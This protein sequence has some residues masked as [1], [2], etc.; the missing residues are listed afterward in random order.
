ML[1]S[2][3][4]LVCKQPL[5]PRHML[6]QLVY[7]SLQTFIEQFGRPMPIF[8]EMGDRGTVI[9]SA[10]R[11]DGPNFDERRARTKRVFELQW[12]DV[13]STWAML[14]GISESGEGEKATYL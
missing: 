4:R 8:P 13:L 2:I 1:K 12:G 6:V 11:F 3:L 9:S 7:Q 14:I 5:Q 10:S